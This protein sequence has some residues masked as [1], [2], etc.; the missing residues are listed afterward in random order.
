MAS[1]RRRSMCTR[2]KKHSVKACRR[3]KGCKYARGTKRRFCRTRKNRK[4]T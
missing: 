2:V 3:L 1:H 4:H